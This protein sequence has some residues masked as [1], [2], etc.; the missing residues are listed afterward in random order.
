[1]PQADR[2]LDVLRG[3]V[4]CTWAVGW[5]FELLRVVVMSRLQQVGEI[6]IGIVVR[7]AVD[8]CYGVACIFAGSERVDLEAG[9][10]ACQHGVVSGPNEH[11]IDKS[12]HLLA[13]VLQ[14][15]WSD[16]HERRNTLVS[17]Q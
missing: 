1:M 2:D 11:H 15:H 6:V 17:S 10:R 14:I 16:A 8:C 3:D 4:R 13:I 12:R 5:G 9:L 7:H